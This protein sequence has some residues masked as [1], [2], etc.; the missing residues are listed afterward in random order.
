ML[1]YVPAGTFKFPSS[2][3]FPLQVRQL[4]IGLLHKQSDHCPAVKVALVTWILKN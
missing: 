3:R 2:C 4:D 1:L